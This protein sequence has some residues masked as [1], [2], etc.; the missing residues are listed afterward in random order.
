MIR[1]FISL[2]ATSHRL[3]ARAPSNFLLD[4]LRT[5]R[6]LKLVIPTG[7]V[8]ATT[9][10]YVASLTTALIERGASGWLNLLV[11]LLCWNAL[12]FAAIGLV[13][14]LRLS[15]VGLGELLRRRAAR[16]DGYAPD[17]ELGPWTTLA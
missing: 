5:R 17:R 1:L 13:S 14:I 6:G 16:R 11:V 7:L 8:L 12:K 4:L 10:L 9:Y 3:L 2:T 15:K